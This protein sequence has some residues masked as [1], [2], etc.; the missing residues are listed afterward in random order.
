MNS[1][2]VKV[3]DISDVGQKIGDYVCPYCGVIMLPLSLAAYERDGPD[4][5]VQCPSCGYKFNPVE[6]QAKHPPRL[7]AKV[8]EEM[9]ADE[10]ETDS[11]FETLD[12]DSGQY[13]DEEEENDYFAEDDRRDEESLRRKG[14]TMVSSSDF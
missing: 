13:G 9:I 2:D 11:I 5:E 12:E 14:Y 7:T 1:N 4:A 6:K 10:D 3:V 8:T